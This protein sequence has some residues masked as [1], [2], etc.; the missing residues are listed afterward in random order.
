MDKKEVKQINKTLDGAYKTLEGI[1]EEIENNKVKL[2]RLKND[3]RC[4][5]E[6]IKGR[7]YVQLNYVQE[8][9]RLRE[10]LELWRVLGENEKKFSKY[11]EQDKMYTK[12]DD[13]FRC[14][15]ITT[16]K[17]ILDKKRY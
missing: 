15:E 12:L 10:Y 16:L 8:L 9:K 5:K 1:K 11:N 7:N 4:E 3:D 17:R 2:R 13:K 6:D 14:E